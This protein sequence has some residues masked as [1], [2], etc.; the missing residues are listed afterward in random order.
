MLKRASQGLASAVAAVALASMAYAQAPTG[1]TAADSA[2]RKLYLQHCAGCHGAGTTQAA[3]LT[4]GLDGVKRELDPG[5]PQQRN[6]YDLLAE[7]FD[8]LR[9]DDASREIRRAARPER[10]DH[11][12]RPARILLRL[13]SCHTREQRRKSNEKP[14]KKISHDAPR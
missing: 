1:P 9:L 6:T 10:H 12:D 2:G 13:D 14:L 11:A 7:G 5:P 4:A 3:L 8:H